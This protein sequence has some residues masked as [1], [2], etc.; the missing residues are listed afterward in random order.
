MMRAHPRRRSCLTVPGGSE[1]MLRKSIDLA[2]DE[3]VLDLEDAVAAD[4]K[5]AARRMVFEALAAGQFAGRHVAV[6]V[7]AIGT[8]WCHADVI[9]LAG[10]DH[11]GLT[12]VLPKIETAGD[13]AFADRLLSGLEA[14]QPRAVPIGLQILIETAV[15]LGNCAV[16]AGASARVQSLIIGYGDLASSLGRRPGA[17]WGFAQ[18]TVLLAARAHG[19]QARDGPNFALD[20]DDGALRQAAEAAAGLGFD[21]KWCIHPSQIGPINTAFT[22]TGAEV[23]RACGIIAALDIAGQSGSGIVAFEGEMIDEAMRPGALRIV[24]R[25]GDLP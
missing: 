21:G 25:A 1:K 18:E 22:P 24:A 6:R 4:H 23:R 3:I 10:L 16:L 19:L 11:P 8:P 14:E 13:L 20:P 12:M 15:G 2:A 5:T 17:S 7:N 9:A